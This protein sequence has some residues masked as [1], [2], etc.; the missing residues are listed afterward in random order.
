M[1]NDHVRKL[2]DCDDIVLRDRDATWPITHEKRFRDIQLLGDTRFRTW[3][4]NDNRQPRHETWKQNVKL[5]AKRLHNKAR[6]L[7]R[8]SQ[9]NESGWR[10]QLEHLVFSL[11]KAGQACSRCQMRFWRS[12]M[13]ETNHD[14]DHSSPY[15][16]DRR[17]HWKTCQCPPQNH[18]QNTYETGINQLLDE[19]IDESVKLKIGPDNE[20]RRRK[21]DR[22]IGL[23]MKG[24]VEVLIRKTNGT[25]RDGQS[26]EYSPFKLATNPPAFPFL[27]L[28]ANA[29]RSKKSFLDIETPA[30]FSIQ[31]FLK[32]QRQPELKTQ[33][34]TED[35]LVWFI[36]YR[37]P[38]WKVYACYV[39]VATGVPRY[40]I[41]TL[42]HG[43]LTNEDKALQLVRIVDYITDWAQD[44]YYPMILR[45][46]NVLTSRQSCD[47]IR[48][49]GS[50]NFSRNERNGDH[51]VGKTPATSHLRQEHGVVRSAT[52]IHYHFGGLAITEENVDS[53]L[54]L[55]K[56]PDRVLSRSANDARRLIESL[57]QHTELIVTTQH[58]L[59]EMEHRWTGQER[60]SESKYGP[61]TKT[62]VYAVL[63][64]RCFLNRSWNVTRQLTCLSVSKPALAILAKAASG[65]SYQPKDLPSTLCVCPSAAIYEAIDCL[66][67]DSAL[68][69]L[70]SALT[71]TMLSIRPETSPSNG[72]NRASFTRVL[73]FHACHKSQIHPIVRKYHGVA[74]KQP[75]SE[76]PQCALPK[77][78]RTESGYALK[79]EWLS[80]YRRLTADRS[81]KNESSRIVFDE[82]ET[83]HDLF[84]CS[85]CTRYNET[86]WPTKVQY[87]T[88]WRLIEEHS[89]TDN[90][91]LVEGQIGHGVERFSRTPSKFCLFT[92]GNAQEATSIARAVKAHLKRNQ[93]YQAT[94]QTLQLQN[95]N[96]GIEESE[97]DAVNLYNQPLLHRE[98]TDEEYSNLKNWIVDL[99]DKENDNRIREAC[100]KGLYNFSRQ[101]DPQS[102]D[103]DE[104]KRKR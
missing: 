23:K 17:E 57:E 7:A 10:S 82:A 15:S 22:A 59:D 91:V 76:L 3:L 101:S 1:T 83:T 14:T 64:Y 24:Q 49:F 33:T 55:S 39:D 31:K 62:E 58:V 36:G 20:E 46:L 86:N 56:A 103:I 37:G 68:Q 60:K 52:S 93:V 73:S 29:E 12:E 4:E 92:I 98:F 9:P 99:Q 25:A 27:I 94:L 44:V 69:V 84:S 13:E 21:I 87:A 96:N 11:D 72:E 95:G 45:Q 42:W 51:V 19:R 50:D 40:N 85:R 102:E 81:F 88:P 65:G 35:A 78:R 28:G 74:D 6:D 47:G 8:H 30:A 100:K 26:F 38:S 97:H 5:R 54:V 32:I 63:E 80:E 34:A 79:N 90:T 71:G 89:A 18:D 66:R 41:H 77:R 67:S 104:R 70:Q 16:D 43:D 75:L 53:L 61:E 48:V 2:A